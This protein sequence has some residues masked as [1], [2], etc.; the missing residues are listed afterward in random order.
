METFEAVERK[1]PQLPV[2]FLSPYPVDLAGTQVPEWGEPQA[3][4]RQRARNPR[5]GPRFAY[6]LHTDLH[7]DLARPRAWPSLCE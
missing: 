4:A 5:A 2:C 6:D 1:N 3:A 7:A